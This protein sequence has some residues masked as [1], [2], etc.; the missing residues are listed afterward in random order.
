MSLFHRKPVQMSVADVAAEIE[1][2]L[3]GRGGP[4][5]WDDF[6]T[7]PIADPRLNAVRKRCAELP[8][9][10]PPNA[11]GQYCG[12]G[13][14]AVLHALIDQLRAQSG[15]ENDSSNDSAV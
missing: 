15:A 14:V 6:C 4:Y 11:P 13:G 8:R 9:E 1:S 2:F 7:C 5:D 3:D 12:N 10:F